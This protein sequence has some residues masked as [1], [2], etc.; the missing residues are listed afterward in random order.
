MG[1]G[2]DVWR[3]EAVFPEKT[4]LLIR[5]MCRKKHGLGCWDMYDYLAQSVYSVIQI[6]CASNI[7]WQQLALLISFSSR[8]IMKC[9]FSAQNLSRIMKNLFC[10]SCCIL[11]SPCCLVLSF[12]VQLH[13]WKFS[14]FGHGRVWLPH[15]KCFCPDHRKSKFHCVEGLFINYDNECTVLNFSIQYKE[16]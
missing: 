3:T 6:S 15:Y 12:W 10:C 7:Q 13:S 8:T 9:H 14:C 16:R 4:Y 2:G 11:I 1:M 5:D